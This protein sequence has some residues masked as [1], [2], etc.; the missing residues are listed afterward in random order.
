MVNKNASPD[1]DKKEEEDGKND[2]SGDNVQEAIEEVPRQ[3][4]A[5]YEYI[6]V[7]YWFKKKNF[8]VGC[9]C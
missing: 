5:S 6:Q 2:S 7:N 8:F 1:L 3:D 4:P 9:Y